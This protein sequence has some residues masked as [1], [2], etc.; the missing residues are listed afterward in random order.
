M[1]TINDKRQL[2]EAAVGQKSAALTGEG[3]D[4]RFH[5]GILTKDNIPC[6]WN[7]AKECWEPREISPDPPP[8]DP[9]KDT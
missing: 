6:F 1:G 8:T 2:A 4:W 7:P 9:P 5:V 3:F